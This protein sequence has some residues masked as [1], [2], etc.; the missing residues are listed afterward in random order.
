M[1]TDAY[2]AVREAFEQ[3]TPMQRLMGQVLE[4]L[5]GIDFLV[6]WAEENPGE[7][8]RILM[9][10]N[11]APQQIATP[12]GGAGNGSGIHL[13]VHPALAPTSLDGGRIIEHESD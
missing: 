5:G 4:E 13:H 3:G 9:A 12:A 8:V 6:D 11:P 1:T 2:P 7:Y 10:A